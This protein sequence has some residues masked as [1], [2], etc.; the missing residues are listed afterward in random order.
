[1]VRS[2]I[3]AKGGKRLSDVFSYPD[4]IR[5]CTYSWKRG[6]SGHEVTC[7]SLSSIQYSDS[8]SLFRRPAQGESWDRGENAQSSPLYM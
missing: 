8:S 3:Q 2:W 6:R 4:L 1:M 5:V 7:I